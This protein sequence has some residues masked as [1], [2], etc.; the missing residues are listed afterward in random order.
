MPRK[1]MSKPA[2]HRPAPPKR[3]APPP[4]PV[5]HAAERLPAKP[6]VE[7][8]LPAKPAAGPKSGVVVVGSL[9]MDL[10]VRTETM[11]VPG[12]TVMGQDLVQNPGGKG[13]NQATAAGR[14]W[15]R[16]TPAG[17]SGARIIG[18]IGEDIFGAAV[19]TALQGHHVDT[20]SILRTRSVPSGISLIIVDRHGENSIVVSGGANAR[21]SATDLL[22][23]RRAIEASSVLTVQL[24][25]PY[26][27]VACAIALAKRAG[28]ITI[29][30]PAPAP[31]EGLPESLYHVDILSPNQVEA[32]MLTGIPVR[33]VDDARRAGEKIL[34][35]GTRIIVFKM[36]SAGAVIVQKDAHGQV[37]TKHVPGFRVQVV[38]TTAA[39][40]GFTGAL[41]VGI[42]E[43]MPLEQAVRFANAAGALTCTKL[44]AM[45][46]IPNRA[47]VELLLNPPE[48]YPAP[49]P[50]RPAEKP[51]AAR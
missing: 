19:V 2:A 42:A 38:D 51:H 1:P 44:G 12:E 37:V 32:Q 9:I 21:L 6:A 7:K 49:I 13:A 5:K 31:L 14:L 39:G 50:P 30:D 26:D 46:A 36:G 3:T 41:A 8:E 4:P 48:K 34:A 35:R 47:Q 24:E 20:N 16:R 23:E 27:T 28:V 45:T 29:L 22:S 43:G 15:T 25:V 17:T 11:P 18:R 33:T 40:D 10:V